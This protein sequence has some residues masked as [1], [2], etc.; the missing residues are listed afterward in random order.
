MKISLRRMSVSKK[1]STLCVR[2]YVTEGDE[3]YAHAV[4][5]EEQHLLLESVAQFGKKTE[6]QYGKVLTLRNRH[7]LQ[8]GE[9]GDS[10]LPVNTN[11][12]ELF[13]KNLERLESDG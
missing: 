6:D 12:V 3:K 9:V 1:I 2:P 11:V 7:C 13:Q 5:Q 10:V 8:N 4:H